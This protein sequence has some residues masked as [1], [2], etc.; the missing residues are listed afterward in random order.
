[1]AD[2]GMFSIYQYRKSIVNKEYDVNK[3]KTK[4]VCEPPYA[5]D[6]DC[7]SKRDLI[8]PLHFTNK[9]I[10]AIINLNAFKK[11]NF[12]ERTPDSE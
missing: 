9:W 11:F 1:M 6:G 4:T 2:A 3:G 7:G 5:A 10:S 8:M 12:T